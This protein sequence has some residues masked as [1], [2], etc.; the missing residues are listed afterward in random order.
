MMCTPSTHPRFRNAVRLAAD[1][2]ARALIL[3]DLY[4]SAIP[5]ETLALL[6]LDPEG[7]RDAD[8]AKPARTDGGYCEIIYW[9]FRGRRSADRA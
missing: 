7:W 8:P 9:P 6:G 1:P 5:P 4:G 3:H 2:E